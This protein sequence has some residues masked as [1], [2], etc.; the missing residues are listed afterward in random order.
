MMM[1]RGLPGWGSGSLAAATILLGSL[2]IGA[3][4]AKAADLGGDCCADL[5]ER[6]AE[7]EATTVR[8][9]NK[10]VSLTISGWVTKRGTWWNDGQEENFYVG[11]RDATL[12]SHVNFSGSAKISADWSAGYT[13][14]LELPGNSATV[15]FCENQYNDNCTFFGTAHTLLSYMWVKS[16]KWGAINWGTQ[17]QATDN[18]LVLRDLSGTPIESNVV[19]YDAVGLF[20]RPSSAKNAG[21]LGSDFTW[22]NVMTCITA[23]GGIGGD[24][25][26]Y[27]TANVRYDSPTFAGFSVST[28]YG[29]DDMW[30]VALKYDFTGDIWKATGAIGWTQQTD[31]GCISPAAGCTNVGFLGG[32]GLPFQGYRKE[33][34]LFQIGG[35]VM[36]VPSGI[37]LYGLYQH[38]D[39]EG[40][41]FKSLNAAGRIV[42][43]NVNDNDVWYTK[44][45]VRRP[46]NALGH[47]VIFGEVAQYND[48]YQGICGLPAG[49]TG[50]P[51]CEAY[52]PTGAAANGAALVTDSLLTGSEVRRYGLGVVQ[53]IDAAAM[54]IFARWQRLELDLSGTNLGTTCV[55]SS[56]GP[57]VANGAAG[58]ALK[59]SWEPSD[60]FQ[61]GGVIFF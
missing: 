26:G 48:M 14:Q 49:P 10:R 45:G 30:D 41:Q 9:G 24:C 20:V 12:S 34:H 57:C 4:P 29:D 18:L 46:F 59:S 52:I 17:R 27:P 31:E 35:S 37:F 23:G 47:T 38:E 51:F 58:Q 5:E 44:F 60:L 40:T 56:A 28:S 2:I 21:D 39:N 16:D 53:E 54:H 32:G 7:L 43:N 42:D 25:N 36:H 8:K 1:F 11:D 22:F 33:A 15:G 6:V 50:N 19:L 3:G 61:L 55:G 13:M